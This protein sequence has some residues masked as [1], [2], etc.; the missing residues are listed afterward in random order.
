M[1]CMEVC[2]KRGQAAWQ[3]APGRD[4][5]AEWREGIVR[6]QSNQEAPV[7]SENSDG[8]NM[9]ETKEEVSSLQGDII[10][11]P[12][13]KIDYNSQLLLLTFIFFFWPFQWLSGK[14]SIC[15]TGDMCLI[16]GLG[17]SPGGGYSNLLQYSCL[18]NPM[19]RGIWQATVHGVTKSWTQLKRLSS[20]SIFSVL[21]TTFKEG[22]INITLLWMRKLRVPEFKQF[23]HGH[24]AGKW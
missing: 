20:I 19:D 8:S 12:L 22:T 16:P 13:L 18:E 9:T 7:Y 5:C 15:N 11:Y 24:T 14:E 4:L 6:R 10:I 2:E 21:T 17:R 3:G 23:T 1:E